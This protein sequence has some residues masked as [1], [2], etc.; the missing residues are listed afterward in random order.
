MPSSFHCYWKFTS[1]NIEKLIF[2]HL[3]YQDHVNFANL[4]V[5]FYTNMC[6]LTT[7][8]RTKIY[9]QETIRFTNTYCVKKKQWLT[10]VCGSCIH[11]LSSNLIGHYNCDQ[12]LIF[13]RVKKQKSNL[14]TGPSNQRF[15]VYMIQS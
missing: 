14:K 5:N 1:D 15:P 13:D 11:S 8:L 7:T 4:F 6:K 9:A 10:R 3:Q 12:T 2:F